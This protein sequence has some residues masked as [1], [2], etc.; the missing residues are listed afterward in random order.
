MNYNIGDTVSTNLENAVTYT[1]AIVGYTVRPYPNFD[2]RARAMYLVRIGQDFNDIWFLE[3][4]LIV[5][6]Q[7]ERETK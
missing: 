6:K 3:E 4:Q 5:V 7:V 1:G 2:D